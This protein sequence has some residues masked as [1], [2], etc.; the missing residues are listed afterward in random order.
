MLPVSADDLDG[1]GFPTAIS[2]LDW[3]L[4]SV[5]DDDELLEDDE[6]SSSSVALTGRFWEPLSRKCQ[7]G[8]SKTIFFSFETNN[9]KKTVEQK[10]T[11]IPPLAARQMEYLSQ[12]F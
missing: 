10:R 9:R 6:S 7:K 4:S 12:L 3:L 5:A 1:N 8:K 2:T 11:Q